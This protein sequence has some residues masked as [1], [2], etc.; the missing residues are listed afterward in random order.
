MKAHLLLLPIVILSSCVAG[1]AADAPFDENIDDSPNV[2]LPQALVHGRFESPAAVRQCG[3]VIDWQAPDGALFKIPMNICADDTVALADTVVR[4]LEEA[5]DRGQR[6]LLVLPQGVNLPPAILAACETENRF[7]LNSGNFVGDLCLPWSAAYQ[8]R[9]GQILATVAQ[10]IDDSEAAKGALAAVY[11]T[12][13]TM[14][15][16]AEMHWRASREEIPNY[17]GDAAFQQSYLDVFDIFAQSFD[18]P[19][20]FEAGHCIWSSD[21]DCDTP[22]QLLEHGV[23]TYGAQRVGVAFWNGAERFYAAPPPDSAVFAPIMDRAAELGVSMGIQTVGNF[24]QSCRFTQEGQQPGEP[25]WYGD[26]RSSGRTTQCF[27]EEGN[28]ITASPR[29]DLVAAACSDTMNWFVQNGGTWAENWTAE[30]KSDGSYNN[31]EA[32]KTA[33]D[34]LTAE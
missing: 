18:A 26:R 25:L 28:D 6:G 20:V 10:A 12:I 11:F 3:S 30:F 8:Q 27:D 23:S 17:P 15:N 2:T 19:V 24:N 21:H 4:N 9:L 13:S 33:I 5:A 1:D 32:C 22:M 34:Q 16:G 14:S 31:S 29:A 7:T